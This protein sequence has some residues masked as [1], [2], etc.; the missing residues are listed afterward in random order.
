MDFNGLNRLFLSDLSG[1]SYR[2]PKLVGSLTC[3]LVDLLTCLLA[4]WLFRH[5]GVFEAEEVEHAVDAD[6]GDALLGCFLHL[7][8]GAERD[9]QTSR[10]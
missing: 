7:W 10:F 8:L 4:M 5:E 9:A 2:T 3:W 6:G 1:L